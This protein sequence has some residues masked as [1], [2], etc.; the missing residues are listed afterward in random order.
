MKRRL[1]RGLVF[2]AVASWGCAREAPPSRDGLAR[3]EVFPAELVLLEDDEFRLQARALDAEGRELGESGAVHWSS[4]DPDAATVTF[5]CVVRAISP[6]T[7]TVRAQSGSLRAGV[8]VRVQPQEPFRLVIVGAPSEMHVGA[9]THLN[10]HLY[11]AGGDRPDALE[12]L[13]SV[14][15]PLVAEIRER[16]VGVDLVALVPGKVTVRAAV[17]RLEAEV[18]VRV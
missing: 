6:G 10:A 8:V 5:E 3:L 9:E 12:I 13:W 17:G 7:T 15:D 1:L 16:E 14:S 11:P 2:L 18:E 4:E